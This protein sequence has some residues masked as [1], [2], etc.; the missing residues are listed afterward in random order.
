MLRRSQ[1]MAKPDPN[2]I[3]AALRKR[4]QET[5]PTEFEM[6]WSCL[7]IP[8]F[9]RGLD[10]YVMENANECTLN[11]YGPEMIDVAV[12]QL[13]RSF[14]SNSSLSLPTLFCKRMLMSTYKFQS[15]TPQSNWCTRN[16]VVNFA[17]LS[18]V[19]LL[20]LRNKDFSRQIYTSGQNLRDELLTSHVTAHAETQLP[21]PWPC[22]QLVFNY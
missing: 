12:K 3:K 7:L 19:N 14:S 11:K 17:I 13:L 10:S 21:C 22:S 6:I 4:F 9:L 5:S 1:A 2:E 16:L 8:R 20:V 15:L 18:L